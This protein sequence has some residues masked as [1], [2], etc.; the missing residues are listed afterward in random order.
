MN[1]NENK[2]A[3]DHSA[4]LEMFFSRKM[5][6]DKINR[7][8][9][10]HEKVS[11]KKRENQLSF[12]YDKK[13]FRLVDSNYVAAVSLKRIEK[14]NTKD[15]ME[16][17]KSMINKNKKSILKKKYELLFEYKN[18]E[19][20]ESIYKDYIQPQ[21]SYI[22][23]H[24]KTL[25]DHKKETQEKENAYK[26]SRENILKQ[27][28]PYEIELKSGEGENKSINK[29]ENMKGYIEQQQRLYELKHSNIL[30]GVKISER[31]VTKV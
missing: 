1:Q 25:E 11:K 12:D 8:I 21:E 17:Y 30:E 13:E 24:E 26:E 20:F 6:I 18:I 27:Q 3:T 16:K 4:N 15:L 28:E 31:E 10:R 9:K 14:Q 29:A 5:E 19:D 7:K 23:M 22:K 2:N